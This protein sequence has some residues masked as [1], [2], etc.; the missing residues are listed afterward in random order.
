MP[1]VLSP[2]VNLGSNPVCGNP[3]SITVLLELNYSLLVFESPESLPVALAR[4]ADIH[5]YQNVFHDFC[6]VCLYALT[7]YIPHSV[8]LG[9]YVSR[10]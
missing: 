3:S 5:I 1:F 2:K 6:D 10:H 7:Q 4:F 9:M 8:G